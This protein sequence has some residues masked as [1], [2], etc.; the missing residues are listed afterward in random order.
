VAAAHAEL[1]HELAERDWPNM[2]AYADAEGALIA[3][4]TARAEEWARAVNW[5]PEP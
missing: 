2:N 3:E 1:E 5:M 4:I